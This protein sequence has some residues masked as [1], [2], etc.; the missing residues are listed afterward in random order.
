MFDD[1]PDFQIKCPDGSYILIEHAGMLNKYQYALD[2]AGK[3]QT[4]GLN[5]YILGY[6]LFVTSDTVDGGIDSHEIERLITL[7]RARFP[8]L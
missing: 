6:T 3:L 1:S 2:L 5:G 8:Y 7:I 4:Y